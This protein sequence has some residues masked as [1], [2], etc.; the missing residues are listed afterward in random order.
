MYDPSDRVTLPYKVAR[1]LLRE[2][3]RDV[4]CLDFECMAIAQAA[5]HL[6]NRG[7]DGVD[8][9]LRYFAVLKRDESLS[10]LA[11]ASL[12]VDMETKI[13]ADDR[14]LASFLGV[15]APLLLLP[16]T[17]FK[18]ND[19]ADTDGILFTFHDQTVVYS[20]THGLRI[21][22]HDPSG[23]MSIDPFDVPTCT[24]S[25]VDFKEGAGQGIE[26]AFEKHEELAIPRA[27]YQGGVG[28]LNLAPLLS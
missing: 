9:A 4:G 26:F 18:L 16:I 14:H 21:E 8:Y 5:W 24:A 20:K 23:L 11:V 15:P 7:L 28:P 12:A 10:R 17:S 27:V 3:A 1:G 19:H 22:S 25:R 13:N 6:T 2:T